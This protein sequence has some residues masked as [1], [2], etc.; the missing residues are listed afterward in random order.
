MADWE[1]RNEEEKQEKQP[2]ERK[3]VTRLEF[4]ICIALLLGFVFFQ[5]LSIRDRINQAERYIGNS[6][7]AELH[8][9]QNQI[10]N[11][12]NGIE[13]ALEEA[14]RILRAHSVEIVAVDLDR[15]TATLRMTA[16]P[17]EYQDGMELLFFVSCDGGASVCVP[18]GAGADRIYAAELEVDICKEALVN[19]HIQ[20]NGVEQ[21][22]SIGGVDVEWQVLPRFDGYWVGS[23][24]YAANADHAMCSGDMEVMIEKPGW[25]ENEDFLLG[26]MRK[27]IRIDGETVR[28]I[29]LC[30]G[31]WVEIQS[32]HHY[33]R[34]EEEKETIRIEDGQ[35]I[36]F[37]FKAED[38][39]GLKYTY[40]VERGTWTRKFGYV[41]EEPVG[42]VM[43]DFFDSR[44][45]IE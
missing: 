45:I 27:E 42:M 23:L 30:E 18:A 35:T 19:V 6:Y 25:L 33:F 7:T 1:Y 15:Q 10:A 22:Q 36:E 37:I 17:K 21:I 29:P 2:K 12:P 11:I 16:I 13:N 20:R 28:S 14:E 8:G 24:S 43:D 26:N 39:H 4:Y 5:S 31:E 34:D 9:L 3:A 41:A 44:L 32:N 38:N 40:L